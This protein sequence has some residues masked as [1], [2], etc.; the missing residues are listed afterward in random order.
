MLREKLRRNL[1]I[2]LA[3]G[4]LIGIVP[5]MGAEQQPE[6]MRDPFEEM[7]DELIEFHGASRSVAVEESGG[8]EEGAD[9][10]IPR[11]PLREPD[12]NEGKTDRYIIKYR[13]GRSESFS[14]KASALFAETLDILAPKVDLRTGAF[15]LLADGERA[16]VHTRGSN[17][18]LENMELLVLPS[19]MLPSELVA[20]L[21]AL[22]AANDIAYL[23][24]DFKLQLSSSGTGE[25]HGGSG[26]GEGAAGTIMPGP[27]SREVVVAVIDSGIDTSH[28]AFVGYLHSAAP[29]TPTSDT[30]RIH[31]THISGVI[32]DV[33]KQTG[34]DIKI[35]P[36]R[37]FGDEGVGAYTSDIIAAIYY[38]ASFNAEVI[39]CSFSSAAYNQAL[40]ES[41]AGCGATVVC[42][43]GNNRRDSDSEPSFPSCYVLPNVISVS[44]V[45]A[46]GSH[47]FYSGYGCNSIDLAAL[48]RDVYSALP[49]NKYGTMSGTSVSCAYVSGVAAAVLSQEYMEPWELGAR[50][51]Y[52]A[53]RLSNLRNKVKDGRRINLSNAL[54]GQPGVTL[55]LNPADDYDVHGRQRTDEE[56]WRLF[57]SSVT[58]QVAAGESHSLVLNSDGSL[59]AFG[60]NSYCQLGDGTTVSSAVPIPVVGISGVVSISAGYYHNLA[61]TSDGTTWSWGDNTYGQLGNGGVAST[62]PMPVPGTA[63]ATEAD[64]GAYHS[65]IIDDTGALWGWGDSIY[66]QL[67]NVGTCLF[68]PEE[69]TGISDAAHIS[70]GE[71]Y[72]VAMTIDEKI[73]IWGYR[74]DGPAEIPELE[75]AAIEAGYQ[76]LMAIGPDGTVYEWEADTGSGPLP[77]ISNI[78]VN[79]L[80]DIIAVSAGGAYGLALKD[81]ATVWEWKGAQGYGVSQVTGLANVA[82]FSAGWNH[83]LFA[84]SDGSIWSMGD[85]TCGQLGD[86]TTTSSAIPILVGGKA[87][88]AISFDQPAY[89]GAIP[90]TGSTPV[91]TSATAYDPSGQ[92]IPNA[93][94]QYSIDGTYPGASMN[95]LT[96]KV[97]IDFTAQPGTLMVK[98]SYGG[99]EAT[100][101]LT[102]ADTALEISQNNEYRITISAQNITSFT[103]KTVTVTY[104][105]TK[106]QLLNAAEQVY[107][108]HTAT[109]AIPGTGLTITAN[110]PGALEF[111][112]SAAIQQG[113]AWAGVITIVKFKALANGTTVIKVE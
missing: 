7:K 92:A 70:A 108:A 76:E 38:S 14:R 25:E 67:G 15:G 54:S 110:S 4:I 79:G 91:S 32:A 16:P 86:G 49:G 37:V 88:G 2:I 66:D 8:L 19:P 89:S 45:N 5:A 65:L 51:I 61:I 39:N 43:V 99:I 24:P 9:N 97:L 102:L 50:L 77:L 93:S 104:D 107:G 84:T 73:W 109:G 95:L 11:T 112:L 41:I 42:A 106:L 94:I 48:G 103:G 55:T 53:D 105:P 40:Y 23:Q 63:G 111:E 82:D 52:T 20:E 78:Q 81:D 1:V 75:G 56:N 28:E 62:V 13:E 36:I 98:A 74:I 64:A 101:Q 71:R 59:W 72:S 68:T 29:A 3:L 57:S 12:P 58:M 35:L 6:T 26:G 18:A 17:G 10:R 30:S 60:D 44:S 69:M 90:L 85:N 83:C 31:G 27:A 100:A 113:D 47:S 22:G 34:A 33:A 80:S 21:K 96:G 46:D 87:A